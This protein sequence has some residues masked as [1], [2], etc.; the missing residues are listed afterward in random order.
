MTFLNDRN[1]VDETLAEGPQFVSGQWLNGNPRLA[2][3]GGVACT[4]GLIVEVGKFDGAAPQL[5]KWKL[6]QVTFER[7]NTPI[8]VLAAQT[9]ALAVIAT[10]F[11][12]FR[13]V[14]GKKEYYHRSNPP[15][16]G[17]RGKLQ[18][19]AAVYG[20]EDYPIAFTFTGTNSI[21]ITEAM[22]TFRE[23]VVDAASKLAA[24]DAKAKGEKAV[25]Y[26]ALAFWMKIAAGQPEKA[27]QAGQQSTV[28][29]PGL[30]LP[31][32]IN[33]DVLG[34]I[35]V[36]K[37]RLVRFQ[38]WNHEAKPWAAQWDALGAAGNGQPAPAGEGAEA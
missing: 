16:T 19:L 22:R 11:C 35:Y 36:G 38:Q 12:W 33:A 31:A 34:Q 23:K 26:P 6:E 30:V 32:E 25:R 10:R 21:A 17:K 27:G 14:D 9:T 28:T 5:P 8:E 37:D 15:K 20:L 7:A 2:Q 1:V 4:G 3:V 18:V 29:P 13:V 24:A